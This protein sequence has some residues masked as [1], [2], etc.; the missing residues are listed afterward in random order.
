MYICQAQ[1]QFVIAQLNCI[2]CQAQSSFSWWAELAFFSFNP[3]DSTSIFGMDDLNYFCQW[4]RTK[5]LWQ[6]EDDLHFL[7]ME[8]D[9]HFLQMEDDL[10]SS[11]NRRRPQFWVNTR[12]T[13]STSGKSGLAAP[14]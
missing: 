14:A 9:L 8:D 3:A 2:Y 11:I 6:M 7:Q 4:K 12:K 1:F 13:K 5:M 10:N